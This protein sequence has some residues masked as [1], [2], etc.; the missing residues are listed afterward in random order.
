[1][2][3]TLLA[4]LLT[5]VALHAGDPAGGAGNAAPGAPSTPTYDATIATYTSEVL[6]NWFKLSGEF[7]V[8]TEGRTGFNF[9]PGNDD[10]Y[11]LFRTRLNVEITPLPWLDI[12]GQAQDAHAIGYDNGRPLAAMEDPLDLRQAYIRFGKPKSWIKFTVGRQLLSYG[13]QHLIGPLDWTNVSRSFDAAK[14]ELGTANYKVDLFASSVVVNNPADAIDH[15]VAGHNLHGAYGSIKKVVPY[16]TLE[17]YVLWKTGGFSVWTGGF[18]LASDRTAAALK[19]FDYTLELDRQGGHNGTLNREAY[20]GALVAGKTLPV[21]WKLR[22][23]AEYEIASGN[24]SPSGKNIETF[25]QLYP[26]EHIFSG[27]LDIM[28]WQNM[29][30]P[31]VGADIKPTKKL[32]FQAD[33]RWDSLDSPRDALYDSTGKASVKPKAGNTTRDVGTELNFTTAWNATPQ[34]KFGAGVG[35]LFPGEFLKLNS[36]GSSMTFPYGFLQR[37][38]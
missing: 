11:G 23:S 30:Q 21:K 22:F 15:S 10:A 9:Q 6:P 3:K 28:G 31:R 25:D 36:S 37:S 7:R 34:W 35:H 24:R 32:Q 1:M 17:P 5:A 13:D 33:Y 14:L 12:F 27:P 16:A 20:A 8:R 38:F 19:G 2:N 18:R 29:R 26:T 4:L